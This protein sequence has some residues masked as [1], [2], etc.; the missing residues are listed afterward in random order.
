[1]KLEAI[2]LKRQGLGSLINKHKYKHIPKDIY[3]Y[4]LKTKNIVE[5]QFLK[6]CKPN[7]QE[8]IKGTQDL[9][10][11]LP[12]TQKESLTEALIIPSFFQNPRLIF[13]T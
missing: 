1:M 4:R 10:F 3:T 12:A 5:W 11:A 6:K 9:A 8:R 2:C 13:N 7:E